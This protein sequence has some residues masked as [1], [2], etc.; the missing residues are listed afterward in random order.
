M[1]ES[2]DTTVRLPEKTTASISVKEDEV[3]PTSSLID[4]LSKTTTYKPKIEVRGEVCDSKI[5]DQ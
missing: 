3:A 5:F 4:E 1:K 2:S